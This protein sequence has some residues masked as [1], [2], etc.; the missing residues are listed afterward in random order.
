MRSKFLARTRKWIGASAL[1]ILVGLGGG[2]AFLAASSPM[3]AA[4]VTPVAQITAPDLTAQNPG[5]ANLVDAVKP[6]VVSITVEGREK[7][8]AID[9]NNND[10]NGQI[11]DLPDDNFL[12]KFFQQFGAPQ[13]RGPQGGP[14]PQGR[15]FAAAGSGFIISPDGYIVTNNHV[16]ENASKVTVTFDNGDT[17]SAKVVGTDE[18][19]DLAVVKVDGATD[20]PFVKFATDEARVGDWVIAVGNPFGLGGTVTAGIVSARG[21]DVAGSNY[22]DFLQID[23]AVNMGNSGGPTFNLK[24]EVIGVN[25]EIFSPNGG[26]V[27]IAFDIPAKTVQQIT[28][29]LIKTGTVTRGFLDVRIQDVSRDI[30]DSVGLKEAKGALITDVTDNGPGAKAGLKSGDIIT[31]VD[32]QEIDNALALS[33]T[34]AGDQPNQTVQLTVWRDGKETTISATLGT[35]S[36][37]GDDNT[38]PNT[39]PSDDQGVTQ[40]SVG[41]TLVPNGNGDGVL[42]QDVDQ[43]SV[44]ADKGFQVGDTILEVDNKK[45][46]TGKQF[47]AAIKAVKDSGRS[48]ALIK[49]ERDGSV[50]FIGLPLDASKG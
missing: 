9:Q 4:Q 48:T 17:K 30:A 31:K 12:K 5:F 47:E 34:I 23:A 37:K 18:R 44:A 20:L 36:N 33:R 3:A 42:V 46:S 15:R 29:S 38:K 40:S 32:G 24:G 10:F 25:T 50:R 11:P 21:R 22:G 6:A 41:L 19:T 14:A 45:V 43:D 8:P 28:S 1:A 16:V 49:A 7:P 39:P 26:N 27:G 35:F 13:G 2:T